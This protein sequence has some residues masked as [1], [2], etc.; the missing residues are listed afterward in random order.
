MVSETAGLAAWLHA[1]LE[2]PGEA[3]R[4]YRF[5]IGAARRSGHPLLPVYMQASLGQYA[6]GAGDPGPGLR[7][8]RDAAAR[9]P[10]SAPVVARAW[11]EVLEGLAMAN[12]GDRNGMRL[13]ARAE[14]R[15]D[16][17]ADAAPVW[18][19][20]MTFD[21][22]KIAGYRA[23]AAS[24]LGLTRTAEAAHRVAS[25]VSRAP[26]Q[27]ALASVDHAR[28]LASAGRLEEA[29][30]LAVAAFDVGQTLGSERTLAAVRRY[31]VGL[32]EAVAGSAAVRELDDRLASAYTGG[33]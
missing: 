25:T 30:A 11:L 13:L 10:R 22:P 2:Q 28:A 15:T 26:K 18:P 29:C 12:L 20:L 1:D 5:A 3:R 6:V 14:R 27:E 19:W 23:T 9:L 8:I 17:S 4:Y 24:R 32:T 33:L 7:L 21:A 31:R 16:I